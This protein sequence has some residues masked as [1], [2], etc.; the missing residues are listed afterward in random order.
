VIFDQIDDADFLL[1]PTNHATQFR[2]TRDHLANG[3]S[4][5]FDQQ[6]SAAG[7]RSP[8]VIADALRG[9]FPLINPKQPALPP[10]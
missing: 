5:D 9:G 6:V 4:G 10:F 7:N 8:K 1:K 2:A 3:V